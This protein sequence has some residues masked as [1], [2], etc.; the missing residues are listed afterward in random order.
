MN[1]FLIRAL[2]LLFLVLPAQGAP[3]SG[4]KTI[5]PTGDYASLTAAIADI[6][7]QT[8]GGA[9]VLELQAAYVSTVETF[10]LVF[11]NL[12]TTA[13]RTLTLRP[14]TGA[15]NLSISTF[16]NT[17]ATVDL[18]G[19]QF[20]TID[21]RPGGVGTAKQLTIANTNTSG[22]ALRFINE[23]SNNLLQHLTFR[24]VNTGAFEGTVVFS[25]TT[26]PNGNDNNTITFCD[27]CD[28]ASTPANGIYAEGTG[29]TTEQNNSGNAITNCNVF[30][31]YRST[32]VD[33]S[34]MFIT[35]GNTG[36]TISGNSFYQTTNRAGVAATVRAIHLSNTSNN[37]HTVTGNFI[38]G[39]APNAG[40]TPWTTTGT[41]QPYIFV[42]IW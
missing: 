28:G 30:N 23:S 22:I 10:P 36:W 5:G 8:L 29:T 13:A 33:A 21:G 42:G 32:A 6:Q 41:T 25:D 12:T 34:G 15:T 31:F 37:S 19:A 3:L 2:A 16:N 39:T 27:I 26:G 11:T 9:L 7:A 38:G 35:S 20:V 17:R 40:G 24:G 4:T 1:R 18:D 14:Q